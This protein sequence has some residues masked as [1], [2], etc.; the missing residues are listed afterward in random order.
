MGPDSL[1]GGLIALAIL[2]YLMYSL[3]NPERF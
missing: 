3:L 1:I 2:V